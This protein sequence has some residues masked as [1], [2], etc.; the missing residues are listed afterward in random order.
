MVS[1]QRAILP[2]TPS[3]R[4]TSRQSTARL[5][6]PLRHQAATWAADLHRSASYS[7]RSTDGVSCTRSWAL[8]AWLLE[9]S[10]SS[11]S[12]SRLAARST[13]WTS[14]RTRRSSLSRSSRGTRALRSPRW[15]MMKKR[16]TL[17]ARSS[18][19]WMPLEMLSRTQRHDGSLLVDASASGRPFRSCT[20]CQLS[21][22]NASQNSKLNMDY[23]TRPSCR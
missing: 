13:F 22:R 11:T 20:T 6:T 19:S 21:S 8:S 2:P 9:L 7:L 5:P 23:T 1:R 3:L 10:S 12:R 18:S 15:S 4:T 16:K 17:A 14:S